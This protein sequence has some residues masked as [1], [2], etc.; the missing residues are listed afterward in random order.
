M[1]RAWVIGVIL[2]GVILAAAPA[3]CA[4]GS[5]SVEGESESAGT[6]GE[7]S[8]SS[9]G[10]LSEASTTSGGGEPMD[11]G[12]SGYGGTA[13]P[14]VVFSEAWIGP[15]TPGAEPLWR[16]PRVACEASRITA[17]E[18]AADGSLY[19]SG[20]GA[21][22]KDACAGACAARHWLRRLSAGYSVEWTRLRDM[23]AGTFRALRAAPAGGVVVGGAVMAGEVMR[24]WVARHD[25]AGEEL[26]S[27]VFDEV[28]VVNDLALGPGGEIVVVGG[29]AAGAAKDLWAVKLAE[30]GSLVWSATYGEERFESAAAVAVDAA[31]RVWV[32][33]GRAD[34][35]PDSPLKWDYWDDFD[36][37][38]FS[39]RYEEALVVLFDA[40]G[41]LSWADAPL[42]AAGEW[43]HGGA[44]AIGVLPGGDAIVGGGRTREREWLA[45]Y[46]AS[47][48][49]IWEAVTGRGWGVT[50]LSVDPGEGTV[51]MVNL[52]EGWGAVSVLR[53]IDADGATVSTVEDLWERSDEANDVIA[54][55]P[56]GELVI[57]GAS[58]RGWWYGAPGY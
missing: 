5:A 55:T 38:S 7:A 25:A 19:V 58:R 54:R 4:S 49:S 41:G 23:D 51:A 43:P 27:V 30:D 17:M 37:W 2:A 53:T 42:G 28:G 47:G 8:S 13:G 21:V 1:G 22:V 35:D 56:G 40:E 6:S 18:Y 26:W 20:Y 57:T 34:E 52:G 10:W 45:R 29:V 3:G 31:G 44:W 36:D 48:A 50:A 11:E 14:E 16:A 32:A 9:A 24:P 33:G 39:P 15:A 12:C 46:D